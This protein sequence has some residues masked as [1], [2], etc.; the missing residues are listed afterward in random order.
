MMQS[1]GAG[2]D[3]M[4]GGRAEVSWGWVLLVGVAVGLA[5]CAST[6]SSTDRSTH[7]GDVSPP[8]PEQLALGEHESCA[9]SDDKQV[10]CWGGQP[11]GNSSTTTIS[12]SKA[13]R[14]ITHA[15]GRLCVL[16]SADRLRCWGDS[17]LQGGG[18]HEFEDGGWI[19]ETMK[20]G[21]YRS[22]ALGDLH[23]CVVTTKGTMSCVGQGR[24]DYIEEGYRDYDQAISFEGEWRRVEAARYRTCGIRTDGRLVCW[25]QRMPGVKLPMTVDGDFIDVGVGAFTVCGVRSTGRIQCWGLGSRPDV[26]ESKGDVDQGVAPADRYRSVRIAVAHACG[27]TVEGRVRCWGLGAHRD[28]FEG[29]SDHDQAAP[30]D[31]LGEAVRSV[32]TGKYH[33]CARLEDGVACWGAGLHPE[34]SDNAVRDGSGQARPPEGLRSEAHPE[35]GG[36]E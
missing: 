12:T 32:G 31:G 29:E 6:K 8:P 28:R 22:V 36:S 24:V 35:T 16:D 27:L 3:R 20:G 9:V 21:H 34:D 17:D 15:S 33:S 13:I 26:F 4:V 18:V 23:A 7:D 11:L 30:V 14:E 5:G 19:P 25:G 2:N 1:R 10:T